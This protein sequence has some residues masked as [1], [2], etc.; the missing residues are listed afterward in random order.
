MFG[1]GK[2]PKIFIDGAEGTAGLRAREL[3]L[4]TGTYEL[5]TLPGDSRKNASA[6]KEM[7]NSADVCLL[8]L[9]DE[10]AKEA[11][12]LVEN[13]AVKI[14]DS[15]SAHRTA[16]G[17]A[18]GF[19]EL[20]SSFKTAIINSKRVSVPGCHA[21]GYLALVYP[22]VKRGILGSGY[23]VS[24]FS[25]T[26]YSGGGKK[27]IAE[28]EAEPKKF[29][30]PRQYALYQEHKHLKEMAKYSGIEPPVFSPVVCPFYSGM[31]VTVPLN[32]RLDK[33]DLYD[34]FASHYDSGSIRVAPL[35]D[36]IKELPADKLAGKDGMEIY[37]FGSGKRIILVALFDNLLKGAAGAAIECLNLMTGNTEDK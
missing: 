35:S 14:L 6:R 31:E 10:A 26:G 16:E 29:S 30:A 18:Y 9:P 5:L 27:L 33:K 24:A 28:Y 34:I 17:W 37:I 7:L 12:S 15:S 1:N 21:S 3:A 11:V 25:L 19:P 32:L 2:K 4:K 36:E 13:P 23:P 20:D 8:C 22:L